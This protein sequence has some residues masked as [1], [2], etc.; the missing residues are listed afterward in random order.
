MCQSRRQKYLN[1]SKDSWYNEEEEEEEDERERESRNSAPNHRRAFRKRHQRSPTIPVS[2]F[3]FLCPLAR[4]QREDGIHM[5]KK[6][7]WG[8]R[9]RVPSSRSSPQQRVCSS[10][11]KNDEKMTTTTTSSSSSRERFLP[12]KRSWCS[13]CCAQVSFE[14]LT[15][16][17]LLRKNCDATQR[18]FLLLH[19]F[20]PRQQRRG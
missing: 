1:E 2:L 6:C 16:R 17:G 20:M 9:I 10:N 7:V 4:A 3:L 11:N 12:A 5:A 19:F 18:P 13:S 14:C 15:K 8:K